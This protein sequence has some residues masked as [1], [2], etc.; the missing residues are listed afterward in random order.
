MGTGNVD[1]VDAHRKILAWE[2]IAEGGL[3]EEMI[4]NPG[5][6]IGKVISDMFAQYPGKAPR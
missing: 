1:V 4:A 6:A 5:P 3:S 2:G